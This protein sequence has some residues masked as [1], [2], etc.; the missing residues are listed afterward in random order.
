MDLKIGFVRCL[1]ERMGKSRDGFWRRIRFGRKRA[2]FIF[3]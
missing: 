1:V 3:V 2:I